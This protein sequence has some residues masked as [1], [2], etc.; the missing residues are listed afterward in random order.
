MITILNQPKRLN[1]LIPA[2]FLIV[3]SI[4]FFITSNGFHNNTDISFINGVLSYNPITTH[5]HNNVLK[6]LYQQNKT[7]NVPNQYNFKDE[8][9]IHDSNSNLD[10]LDFDRD[11]IKYI[12]PEVINAIYQSTDLDSIDWSR[13]AYVLYATSSSHMCN[14]MMI[15]AELR[16]FN[17]RAEL[18]LLVKQEFLSDL[19][20]HKHEYETLTKFSSDYKVILKPTPVTQIGGDEVDIWKSSFTKLMV[21]NESDYDRIIYLDADAIVLQGN[22]D[23]LFFLPPVKLAVPT[24]YWLTKIQYEKMGDEAVK[25]YDAKKYGFHPLTKDQ[26][27]SKIS[28]LIDQTITPFSLNNNLPNEQKTLKQQVN[29]KNFQTQL[30]NS[31]PNY[32]A[33]DEFQLTNIVMVIQPSRELFARVLNAIEN[34]RKNEYDM[35]LVQNHLFSLPKILQ[36]QS[37]E[38]FNNYQASFTNQVAHEVPE[39]MILPHQVYGTITPELNSQVEHFSYLAD[40]HEQVFAHRLL[41]T[42]NRKP[43]YYETKHMEKPGEYFAENIK[44][45]HFSDAPVPKPWFKQRP[46][47]EYMGFRTRCEAHPDFHVKDG[48]DT[49]IVAPKHKT[50]DCSAGAKWESVHALF[51]DIRK[52]VC[53]LDLV[54]TNEDTY[55]KIIN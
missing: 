6:H 35:D 15:F 14:S 18:V 4:W 50:P 16:K 36:S 37:K 2:I 34:K 8:N 21:F 19:D 41:E 33:I 52:E 27:D 20:N 53:G 46:D 1:K 23:E 22:L 11:H 30:Y 54:V 28:K 25:K 55:H 48:G 47:A 9:I 38:S 32:S 24:A 44:Y 10:L 17:T 29:T 26:R 3:F 31:L 39:F 5:P 43:A 51:K 13:F 40:T 49:K 12:Y 42:S 7:N 45:L